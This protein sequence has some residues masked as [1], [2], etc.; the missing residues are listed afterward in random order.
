MSEE[1]EH[2]R[3]E[4]KKSGNDEKAVFNKRY[5]KSPYEFYGLR[6]PEIRNIVK[7]Y[8]N[9]EFNSA[10]NLF[11][12][13]WNS[14]N[15]EEMSFALYIL[16]NYVKKHPDYV[17][18]FLLERIEK[19]KTWD[20]VDEL[21]SHILG[22]ILAEDM[23]RMNEIRPL[24]ESRNPWMRRISIVSTYPLIKKNR[25]DLTLRLAERLVYDKDAY[26]QKGAGWM[27]R[28]A[29]KKN[30]LAVREFILIHLNMKPVAFSYATEKMTELREIKK[31]RKKKKTGEKKIISEEI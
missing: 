25:I 20:H 2:I 6:V 27:L 5:L 14:G 4:L 26:V 15:H 19:A 10:L 22:V 8:K 31:E 30:R 24:F 12:E 28:E 7:K 9:L 1:I 29:G 16:G 3:E 13:L 23:R 21:S 11:D 18:K 17:W